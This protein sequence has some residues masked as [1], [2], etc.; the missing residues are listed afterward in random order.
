MA[1]T[2]ALCDDYE[3]MRR[4]MIRQIQKEDG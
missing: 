2:E 1:M 3:F 4:R